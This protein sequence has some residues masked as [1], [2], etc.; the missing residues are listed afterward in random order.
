MLFEA[1]ALSRV[2]G[3]SFLCP[4]L[5]G[6]EPSEV[7]PPLGQFQATRANQAETLEMV[8]VMSQAN[9]TNLDP[10]VLDRT[11]VHWWPKLEE[12]LK[13][14]TSTPR[15]P[16]A[17][18]PE[19]DILEE[20]LDLVRAQAHS[21]LPGTSYDYEWERD[22]AATIDRPVGELTRRKASAKKKAAQKAEKPGATV[23]DL[24]EA[25][26]ASLAARDATKGDRNDPDD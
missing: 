19:K 12:S 24:M 3:E 23:I 16:V 13:A 20:I 18:R 17:Q 1:G 22:Y 8:R 10:A 5:L 15:P 2:V 6:L 25:L 9:G 11:F 21:R 14:I 4:Y 7:E 26:K